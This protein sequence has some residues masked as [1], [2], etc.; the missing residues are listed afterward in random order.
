MNGKLEDVFNALRIEMK[1]VL[2]SPVE[3]S[4]RAHRTSEHLRD[5]SKI[6]PATPPEFV[7][8]HMLFSLN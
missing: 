1:V 8:H 3:F 6:P 7:C 2:K 4:S 5:K